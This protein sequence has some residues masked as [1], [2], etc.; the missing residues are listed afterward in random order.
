MNDKPPFQP[1]DFGAAAG[2]RGLDISRLHLD[3]LDQACCDHINLRSGQ[4]TRAVDLGGGSGAQSIRMA[5]CGA[6]V[7]LID[8][9]D[10]A[11]AHFSR[12]QSEGIVAKGR[13]SILKKDFTALRARDIP[14]PFDVLYS[15]RAIHFLPYRQARTC[16]TLMFRQMATDGA[17]FISAA[18]IGT[19]FGQSHPDRN[20][21]IQQRFSA[22]PAD[23]QAKYKTTQKI[24]VYSEQDMTLLLQESGFRNIRIIPSDF[25]NIKAIAL[26]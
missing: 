11:S 2:G 20:K 12:A 7:M 8:I 4:P 23:M 13:L 25:G 17:V 16:L 26:K 3:A 15:Q 21:P 24:A 1:G 22:L 9:D 5:I 10:S 19:E 18:G 14:L 6:D